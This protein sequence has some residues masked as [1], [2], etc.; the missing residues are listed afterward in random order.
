MKERKV[1]QSGRIR[2][3]VEERRVR[4]SGRIRKGVEERKVRQSGRVWKIRKDP[5]GCGRKEGQEDD[6][7]M[8]STKPDN[9]EGEDRN[10]TVALASCAVSMATVDPMG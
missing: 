8:V 7:G 3:G 9:H 5:E 2:K 1:R 10:R 4:Q 6:Q